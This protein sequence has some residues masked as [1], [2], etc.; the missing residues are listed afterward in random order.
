MVIINVLYQVSS[1]FWA[2]V[3]WLW[4]LFSYNI[5]QV[6]LPDFNIYL[7]SQFDNAKTTK[8]ILPEFHLKCH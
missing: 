3:N 6:I 7:D 5:A 4:S 2:K 1:A 8:S